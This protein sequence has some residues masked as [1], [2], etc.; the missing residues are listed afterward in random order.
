MSHERPKCLFPVASI[1]VILFALEFL[2]ANNV[3]QVI[4]VSSKDTRVFNPI[5]QTVKESHPF[6]KDFEVKAVKLD[7]PVSLA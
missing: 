1:P 5:I 6:T 2:A 3:K 4:I 7:N